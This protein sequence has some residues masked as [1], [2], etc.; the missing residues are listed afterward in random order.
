[1]N[2]PMLPEKQNLFLAEL[3]EELQDTIQKVQKFRTETEMRASVLNDAS[4]PT[5]ASKYWQCIREQNMMYEQLR[6][7]SYE[8]RRREAKI[9][10]MKD[11][12]KKSKDKY[13]KMELQVDMEEM[14][15]SLENIKDSANDRVREIKLWSKIKSELDDG[16]FNTQDVNAHQAKSYEQNLI[17][18]KNTLTPGSSQAEVINVL[19]PLQTLQRLNRGDKLSNDTG[20]VTIPI[21]NPKRKPV[22]SK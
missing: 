16:S 11:K 14:E 17:N 15:W 20:G 10:G 22:S 21:E 1:M 12:I 7:Q 5:P 4:H 3:K 19:G 8:Y 13:E 9:L 6:I 2:Y 18:R